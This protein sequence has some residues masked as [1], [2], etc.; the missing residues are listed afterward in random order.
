MGIGRVGIRR[1]PVVLVVV[2]RPL[3]LEGGAA[4]VRIQTEDRKSLEDS[5]IVA[6]CCFLERQVTIDVKEGALDVKAGV[7]NK[8]DP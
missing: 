3:L 8:V 4:L 1:H 7:Y 6:G 5:S 2:F